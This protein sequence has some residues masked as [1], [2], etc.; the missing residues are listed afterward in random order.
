[1]PGRLLIV[2]D[3]RAERAL[4]SQRQLTS[5]IILIFSTNLVMNSSETDRSTPRWVRESLAGGSPPT[6][7]ELAV[8]DEVLRAMRA[9]RFGT[10]TVTI[11]DGRPLQIE[12]TEK[13]RL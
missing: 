12:T 10:V 3:A 1:M 11:Q 13:K 4:V 2:G 5:G 9:I 7:A 8:I 6:S